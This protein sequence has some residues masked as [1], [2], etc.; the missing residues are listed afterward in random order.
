MVV[1]YVLLHPGVS[2]NPL[3]VALTVSA[4]AVLESIVDVFHGE[5]SIL[6]HEPFAPICVEMIMADVLENIF[7]DV[8]N[9]VH[10]VIDIIE[11]RVE[12]W[13]ST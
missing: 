5:S 12:V 1:A 6:F 9:L 3:D 2:F 11:N 7:G 13:Q 10:E 8:I 4:F